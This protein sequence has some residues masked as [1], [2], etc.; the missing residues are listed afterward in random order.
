MVVKHL[1]AEAEQYSRFVPGDYDAYCE[2]MEKNG[3]W[4][5][6]LTLQVLPPFFD[7]LLL[8]SGFA[9]FSFLCVSLRPQQIELVFKS[10]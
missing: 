8:P 10:T 3:T 6:H 4:G 9:D 1:R 7:V 2:K 5:D